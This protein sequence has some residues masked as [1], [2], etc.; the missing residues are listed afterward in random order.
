MT[1]SCDLKILLFSHYFYYSLDLTLIS[2]LK[3]HPL[4]KPNKINSTEKISLML[5]QLNIF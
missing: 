3:F 2:L 1:R 4:N 5:L